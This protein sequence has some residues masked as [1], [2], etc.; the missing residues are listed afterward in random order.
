MR[1]I[2]SS[3]NR[4]ERMVQKVSHLLVIFTIAVFVIL[5]ANPLSN[6][7]K[8]S[9][10][11]S[12][13][14]SAVRSIKDALN[15]DGSIR[16]DAHGSFDP[17]GYRVSTDPN[18]T[19]RFLSDERSPDV[20]A[21]AC[22]DGWDDRFGANG[23]NGWVLAIAVAG[24]DV[25]VGGTFTQAGGVAA[26]HIAKWNGS[27][28]SAL[29]PGTNDEVYSIAVAG[30]DVYV[31]GK[32]TQAGG[33]T[34]N[35]IAKW[36]GASWSA[37]GTGMNGFVYSIAV[38]S[39]TGSVFAGGDFTS[40]GAVAANR[41]ARWNG[42]SWNALGAGIGTTLNDHVY[43]VVAPSPTVDS[44]YVGGRFSTAGGNPVNNFAW[45]TGVAWFTLGSGVNGTVQDIDEGSSDLVIVGN[46]TSSNGIRNIARW[47]SQSQEWIPMGW[48]NG[49]VYAVETF[50]TFTIGGNYTAHLGGTFSDPAEKIAIQNFITPRPLGAGIPGVGTHV[51]ALGLSFI[52]VVY[53]GG[54]F[55]TAGCRSSNNFGQYFVR[56]WEGDESNDW[57]TGGNWSTGDQTQ[58]MSSA[59]ISTGNPLIS[60]SNV[61]LRE[62][63]IENSR[64][65]TISAGRTL[66]VSR[67]LNINDGS[68]NGNGVVRVGHTDPNSIYG[69]NSA[70][71]IATTLEREVTTNGT[72]RFPVGRGQYSP[73]TFTNATQNADISVTANSG[74]YAGSALGLPATRLL[75]YWNLTDNGATGVADVTFHYNDSDIV[76]TEASYQAYRIEDGVATALPTVVNTANNTATVT[77]VSADADFT[78]AYAPPPTVATHPATGIDH[79]RAQLNGTAN[80][81]G[82]QG[83]AWFRFYGTT[84]PGACVESSGTVTALHGIGPGTTPFD[85]IVGGLASSTTYYYCALAT[86]G[87]GFTPTGSVMSFTT[88]APT[89][90][91]VETSPAAS[92]T[93]AAATL[94]GAA[95]PNA[96][97]T[98]GWFRYSTT[99]PGTC[100]DSF[101]ARTPA[102]GGSALGSG[103]DLVGFSQSVAGLAP[104]T[105]YYFC[106]VAQNSVGISFGIVRSFTTPRLLIVDNT[107]DDS[108]LA[109]C[110]PAAG[111]CSLRGAALAS[112]P[113][114]EIRFLSP[115]FDSAQTITLV[116]GPITITRPTSIIGPSADF[117]T[118]TG[119]DPAGLFRVIDGP[120]SFTPYLNIS[121]MRLFGA[122][123]GA[124]RVQVGS[125]QGKGVTARMMVFEG[126]TGVFAGGVTLDA[127]TQGTFLDSTFKLNRSTDSDPSSGDAITAGAGS[128][129]TIRGC[130]F[131]QNR[132][133][134]A[135][136]AHSATVENSTF[137]TNSGRGLSILLSG[138]ITASTITNNGTAITPGGV[139]GGGAGVTVRNSI[140]AANRNNGTLG[141]LAGQF[142][143][144]GYNLIGN[145]GSAN[146]L[147]Q[148][149]DQIG[150]SI[151]PLDPM[152]MPIGNNGGPTWTRVP[153]TGS[154]VID[155]GSAFGLTTDQRGAPRTYDHPAIP[156]TFGP[157]FADGTDIG[158]FE[159]HLAPTAAHVYI[160]GRVTNAF[161]VGIDKVSVE[162]QSGEGTTTTAL[163][164]PFGYFVIEEVEVGQV[165]LLTVRSKRYTFEEPTRVIIVNDVI[166]NLQIM[167]EP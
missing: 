144:E 122:T 57:H 61:T 136:V 154:S 86:S 23:L 38:V 67:N 83:T 150:T 98:T 102:T 117:L 125:Q 149:G 59:T 110:T 138:T 111:D 130:T 14:K 121:R 109:L 54:G 49:P 165:Y 55:A 63:R 73:A 68:I 118:I 52:D 22:M 119:P 56:Q 37:L 96:A 126:N 145:P 2:H 100:N 5:S 158:A 7:A 26:N 105:T 140:I 127:G 113:G 41:I 45:W 36:N 155:R 115:M 62:L 91:Q 90:P 6:V 71:Y 157:N 42:S 108:S 29:G 43:K 148:I 77:G 85:D 124:I 40:A 9:E 89:A 135:V 25:Y 92:I 80:P 17:K 74:A 21:G 97:S 44:V 143:S 159:V 27:S 28:W 87:V 78:L 76:G 24:N 81:H 75:R 31:G 64:A 151:T 101:G 99:N 69:G 39:G 112:N 46:F 19:P 147:N 51:S 35:R 72:F 82:I 79:F 132:G 129:V 53:A 123:G 114:D 120:P 128:V 16:P 10:D 142:I 106:A 153:M 66:T 30:S 139:L 84:N 95:D 134:A 8:A 60:S 47:N 162:L 58:A 141:D 20:A 107:T 166:D 70:H 93:P 15:R 48:T 34:A 33:V 50:G 133:L 146:W 104:S 163:T 11:P 167:A 88:L 137:D 13:S 152:L 4:R 156:N 3:V 161:G 32:F 18:G 65:L 94:Q 160:A 12:G 164:N 131:M 116:N 1:T 103:T